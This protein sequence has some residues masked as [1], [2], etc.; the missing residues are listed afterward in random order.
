MNMSL[1][2]TSLPRTGTGKQGRAVRFVPNPVLRETSGM[3]VPTWTGEF[4]SQDVFMV[5]SHEAPRLN[6]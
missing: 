4:K 1:L 2:S 3:Q 6:H 5:R